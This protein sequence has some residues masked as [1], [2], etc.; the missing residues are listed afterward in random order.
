MSG[1]CQR[2]DKGLA[3]AGVFIFSPLQPDNDRLEYA[4]DELFFLLCNEYT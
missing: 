2:L 1:L 3:G 4:D